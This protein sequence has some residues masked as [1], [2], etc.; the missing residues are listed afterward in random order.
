MWLDKLAVLGVDW[1]VKPQ[2][3]QKKKKMLCHIIFM[4]ID[5]EI[6]CKV[7]LPLPLIKKRQLALTGK[8]VQTKH[9]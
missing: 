1:A 6:I 5:N 9:W 2:F 8:S 7:S 4:E 3:Y